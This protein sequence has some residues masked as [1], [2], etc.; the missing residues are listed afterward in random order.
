MSALLPVEQPVDNSAMFA[1]IEAAFDFD[2]GDLELEEEKELVE[3]KDSSVIE[4]EK[5]VETVSVM[6]EVIEEESFDL[7][8]LEMSEEEIKPSVST[9]TIISDEEAD[10]LEDSLENE[11]SLQNVYK[12]QDAAIA[13]QE[14]EIDAQIKPDAVSEAAAL[15]GA[16]PACAA[17][18]Q[19]SGDSDAGCRAGGVC[20][21]TAGAGAAGGS[22]L[23]GRDLGLV[24]YI[25]EAFVG[26]GWRD[27]LR[28]FRPAG[29]GQALAFVMAPALACLARRPWAGGQ[30]GRRIC[31]VAA[32]WG[33]PKLP[34]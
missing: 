19:G 29:E 24:R 22:V 10:F 17:E 33:L 14:A 9:E 31:C 25:G 6:P 4:I 8:D 27:G 5:E 1:E 3:A 15:L 21:G 11:V 28:R 13:E 34:K 23:P 32:F 2:L 12:A 7:S 26:W 20:R 18:P 16:G 30:G